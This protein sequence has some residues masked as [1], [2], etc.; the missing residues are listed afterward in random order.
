MSSFY[1][2]IPYCQHKCAYCDFYSL[3]LS[4]RVVL[5]QYVELL[6]REIKLLAE[7][8]PGQGPLET[9]FF[10]GGTPS[11]LSAE[12]VDTILNQLTT[13]FGVAS[14]CEISLEANPGTL[15]REKLQNYRHAGI[16]R[17]SLGVQTLNDK[18]LRQLGRIH[19]AEE[20]R[21]AIAMAR[22]AGFTNLSLDLIFALPGQTL[23]QL[24]QDVAGLLQLQPEHLSLYG[25]SF[26]PGTPL[27]ERQRQGR[28]TEPDEQFYAD[29]YLLI[30]HLLTAA[31]FDHYEISNFA[32]PGFRCRHN[33]NY[34][35]RQTC[36]AVGCGA[37]SFFADGWGERW[38]ADTSLPNYRLRLEH[39]ELPM[40]RLEGFDRQAA[41]AEYIY[42]TLRTADGLSRSR[43]K[44][45]FATVPEQEFAAAFERNSETLKRSGDCWRFSLQGWLLYDHLISS[46]L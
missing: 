23:A 12:Q 27:T 20:A 35:Q 3:P 11:L 45:L 37:H 10:G 33:Q 9:I 25:L 18:Q 28:I 46:F 14:H 41:M 13:S 2:H 21:Q 22:Q 31:G 29:S 38:A 42:L 4:S 1:L 26:E 44:E 30:D 32:R 43:F 7:S 5:R 6:L 39:S 8:R 40:E 24:E 16:N 34:W 17:L 15:T 19:S 36:L